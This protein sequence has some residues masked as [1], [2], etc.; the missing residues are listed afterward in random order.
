M[1]QELGLTRQQCKTLTYSIQYGAGAQRIMDVFG[2]SQSKARQTIED[3]Y[4]AY[5]GIRRVSNAAE[6]EVRRFGKMELWSGRFRHFL[7]RDEARKAFNSM[8]QGGAADIVKV[9]MNNIRKELPELRML[10][11][12]HD[13]LV[14]EIPTDKVDYY[15]PHIIN[16]MEHPIE[17]DDIHLKLDGHRLGAH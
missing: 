10:L 17:Q 6:R 3:W 9:S 13:A 1:S 5:P 11:Q 16:I 12:I 14:F 15:R 4:N 7:Y 2:Y 8:N